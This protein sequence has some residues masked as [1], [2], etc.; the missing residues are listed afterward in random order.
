M[1]IDQ[2]H[3][4]IAYP[5]NRVYHVIASS[6]INA[7]TSILMKLNS[8]LCKRFRM[9][10]NRATIVS[11]GRIQAIEEPNGL[12]TIFGFPNDERMS[13]MHVFVAGGNAM[14]A[15]NK[16]VELLDKKNA[17]SKHFTPIVK[18]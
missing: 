4:R 2:T 10:G 9:H 7:S 18:F 15:M 12:A 14:D 6:N 8:S 5:G 11:M 1:P 17:P 3:W 16:M 13:F